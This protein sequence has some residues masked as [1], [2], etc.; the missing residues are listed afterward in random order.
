V[1]ITAGEQSK[2]FGAGALGVNPSLFRCTISLTL[3]EEDPYTIKYP[4]HP[5]IT[6]VN[7]H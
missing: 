3:V 7:N 5:I 1:D 6:I 4:I 2:T